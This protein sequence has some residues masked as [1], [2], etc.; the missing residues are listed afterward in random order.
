[1]VAVSVGVKVFIGAVAVEVGVDDGLGV[2]V[3]VSSGVAV[4]VMRGGLK[5]TTT[6]PVQ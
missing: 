1:M 2:Q 3:N 4:A 6:S 5:F